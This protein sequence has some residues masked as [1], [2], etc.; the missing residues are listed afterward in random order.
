MLIIITIS[1]VNKT[2]KK[3]FNLHN[4]YNLITNLMKLNN[5]IVNF[6][7]SILLKKN[8]NMC[9]RTIPITLKWA[10]HTIF[11]SSLL[12]KFKQFW[13]KSLTG[14][15]LLKIKTNHKAMINLTTIHINQKH[16]QKDQIILLHLIN[17]QQ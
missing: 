15:S 11:Q 8:I 5:H 6:W 10:S 13:M 7:K 14:R 17:P 2:F 4:K 1:S 9:I 12:S 16:K 3:F